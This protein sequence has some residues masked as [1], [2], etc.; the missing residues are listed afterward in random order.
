VELE[1]HLGRGWEFQT[2]VSF[3]APFDDVA[4]WIRPPM[5]RLEPS[6]TGCK[7]IGTTSNPTMYASEW[8]ARLPFSFRV[9]GGTEL[10]EAM[11]QLASRFTAAVVT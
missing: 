11:A 4:R 9:E 2:T 3:D 8:L 10:R 7:L 5:G 6:D 1:E